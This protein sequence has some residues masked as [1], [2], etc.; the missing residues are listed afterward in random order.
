MEIIVTCTETTTAIP[1]LITIIQ[2]TEDI[3]VDTTTEITIAII[4]TIVPQMDVT[5]KEDTKYA[6][7]VLL[8]N[9][10]NIY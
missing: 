7:S 6:T 8:K 3:M 5:T 10:K 4:P 1:T 9:L 2:T